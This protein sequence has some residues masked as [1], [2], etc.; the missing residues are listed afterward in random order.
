MEPISTSVIVGIATDRTVLRRRIEDRSEQIFDNG[1]VGEATMLG[2]KYGWDS[3]AM[4]GNI[5]PLVH[6]YL[7]G[8]LSKREMQEKF[9]TLDWRLAKRQLT[10][11][12]RNPYIRWHE[13]TEAKKYLRQVLANE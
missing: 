11:L 4:T 1:V 3:E 7:E 2:K 10:W 5:Y 8:R 13:L 9:T 6:E 12:K